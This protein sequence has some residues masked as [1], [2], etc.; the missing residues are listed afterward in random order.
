[1]LSQT[2]G[3][4]DHVLQLI[5]KPAGVESVAHGMVDL[6]GQGQQLP[7]V[8]LHILPHGENGQ[9]IGVALGQMEVEPLKG[10]PW[11]H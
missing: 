7:A 9:K 4:A 8:F 5:G 1:M 10:R 3:A 2:I 6:D 11:H